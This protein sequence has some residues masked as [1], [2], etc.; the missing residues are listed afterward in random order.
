MFDILFGRNKSIKSSAP[1]S[2]SV[3][4]TFGP[5]HP[6]KKL[7]FKNEGI[8]DDYQAQYFLFAGEDEYEPMGGAMDFRGVFPILRHAM[9]ACESDSKYMKWGW[10]HIATFHNGKFIIRAEWGIYGN[11]LI[12]WHK[13]EEYSEYPDANP[14]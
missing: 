4:G 10:A 7:E 2:Y 3:T 11:H 1:P 13:P 9:E 5:H 12:G 8:E 6:P 14:D